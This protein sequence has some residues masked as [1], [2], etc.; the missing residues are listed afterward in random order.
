MAQRHRLA[1]QRVSQ[2]KNKPLKMREPSLSL[3]MMGLQILESITFL[4]A[5]RAPAIEVFS[6]FRFN[7]ECLN[8]IVVLALRPPVYPIS[9]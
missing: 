8:L 9:N 5:P 3:A 6:V 7:F 1:P 2:L 4:R